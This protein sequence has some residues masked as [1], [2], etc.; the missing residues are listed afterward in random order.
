[1]LDEAMLEIGTSG[2][3]PAT[4]IA[5]RFVRDRI[6]ARSDYVKIIGDVPSPVQEVI[7]ALG[8]TARSHDRDIVIHTAATERSRMGIMSSADSMTHVPLDTPLEDAWAI[9]LKV[10]DAAVVPTLTTMESFSAGEA[11]R[12]ASTGSRGSADVGNTHNHVTVGRLSTSNTRSSRYEFFAQVRSFKRV[13]TL[14][15]FL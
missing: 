8:I 12:A 11:K 13:R 15:I 6:D 1:M 14:T 3:A 5:E 9:Q 4:T 10:G 7:G 2:N